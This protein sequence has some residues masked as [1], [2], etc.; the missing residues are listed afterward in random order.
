MVVNH[1]NHGLKG[2]KNRDMEPV[3]NKTNTSERNDD[4]KP[5]VVDMKKNET[6]KNETSYEKKE[7]AEPLVEDTSILEKDNEKELSDIPNEIVDEALDDDDDK[8][9]EMDYK[10]DENVRIKHK[11]KHKPI[12]KDND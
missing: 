2:G 5:A 7:N 4:I 9:S 11:K 10:L 1:Y 8:D 12:V 6:M 3:Q